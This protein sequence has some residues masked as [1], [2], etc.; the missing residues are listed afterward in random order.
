MIRAGAQEDSLGWWDDLSL[1]EAGMDVLVK[2][3]PR[4]AVRTAHRMALAA[5]EAEH[6]RILT[7]AGVGEGVITLLDLMAPDS[8]DATPAVGLPPAPTVE[9][10]RDLLAERASEIADAQ[11]PSVGGR[12]ADVTPAAPG[13]CSQEQN[14]IRLAAGYLAG[15]P[16]RLVVPFARSGKGRPG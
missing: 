5:A 12:V 10:L 3:F 2:L 11:P 7:A 6:R 16:G 9:A 15:G 14:A 8:S 4:S 13:G 1:T